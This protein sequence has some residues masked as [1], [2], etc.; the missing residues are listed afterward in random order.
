MNPSFLRMGTASNKINLTKIVSGTS[1]TLTFINKAIPVYNNAKPLINNTKTIV[2][3]FINY[4]KNKHQ[5]K[6]IKSISNVK[7]MPK[8]KESNSTITFFQ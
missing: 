6:A 1:K 3:G 4:N 5:D 8:E 7:E 2:K